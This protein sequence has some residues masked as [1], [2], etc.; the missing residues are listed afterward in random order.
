MPEGDTIHRM[1]ARLRALLPG[2]P[3]TYA[4]N[5]QRGALDAL[6][7]QRVEGI[8]AR[9]KNLLIALSGG[10]TL[11]VHL[12]IA[13]RYSCRPRPDEPPPI[14]WATLV[15]DTDEHRTLVWKTSRAELMRT[16]HVRAAPG[17]RTLGPDLLA[18]DCDLDEVMRRARATGNRARPLGE[19][20]LDQRV[21]AGIGNVVRCEA[22]YLA[23][24]DP[25]APTQAVDDDTLRACFR[26]AQA[27]LEQSVRTGRRDTTHEAGERYFVYGRPSRPCL[28]CGT[29]IRVGRQGD[30]ARATY[31]CPTCQKKPPPR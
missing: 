2:E 7:G 1:A 17:M 11:R 12:G 23:R 6:I 27:I 3:V 18:D 30:L 13:G 28:T 10:H 29:R 26:H 4:W 24:A 19:I 16:A 14:H 15:L 31:H 8:E 21:A 9:G 5:R 20:L 25:F 22:L